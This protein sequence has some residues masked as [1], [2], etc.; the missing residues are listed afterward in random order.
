MSERR[1]LPEHVTMP[2]LDVI[3]RNSLDQD[4]QH[5]AD[6]RAA[7]G[8]T[9]DRPP[10]AHKRAATVVAVFGLLAVTAAVQTNEN[11]DTDQ[12][13]REQ[14]IEQ[15]DL[16]SKE[17]RAKTRQISDLRNEN[18]KLSA[19]LARVTRSERAAARDALDV[20]GVTGFAAVRGQGVQVVVDDSP[21]GSTEGVVQD[22]DLATL[23]DGLWAAGAE[24]V[25]I[26][27]RR[28]TVISGI[29]TAGSAINIRNVPIRPPYAVRAIGDV[30]TLQANFVLTSSGTR[31][32]NLARSFGFEYDMDNVE[33]LTLP[34]APPPQLGWAQQADT[35]TTTKE[36]AP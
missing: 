18:E 19:D 35:T 7:A 30:D 8:T 16:R 1:P 28:I 31:F 10:T 26:N 20:A 32:V 27:G 17:L 6:A 14:L 2:L 12:R 9:S 34:A 23:V 15:I 22:E 33:S 13:T 4:Y 25:A 24:A 21:D 5:V 11:A 3:T 29:R 36:V